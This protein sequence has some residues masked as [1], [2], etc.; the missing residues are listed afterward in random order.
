MKVKLLSHVQLF[1][2]PWT[3]AHQAPQSMEFSRQELYFYKLIITSYST[4]GRDVYS[5][6][7]GG[8][9][10]KVLNLCFPSENWGYVADIVSPLD[11]K[12]IK[13][14]NPKGNQL[15]ILTGRTN[16]E[17]LCYVFTE[18]CLIWSAKRWLTWSARRK[19]G[20]E[21]FNNVQYFGLLM[22]GPTHQKTP[23]F[24][25]RLR[26]GGER[27]DRGWGSCVASLTHWTW[28]WAD[29]RRY[30]RTGKPGVLQSMGSQR[31]GHN[32][33][34]EQQQQIVSFLFRHHSTLFLLTKPRFYSSAGVEHALFTLL[35]L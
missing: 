6:G 5:S 8:V 33:V 35:L 10:W 23:R 25:E 13:S 7:G 17:H 11:C 24:W 34:I 29:S 19:G 31:V 4:T 14:I 15:W 30:W 18:R 22:W 27:G 28:I 1:V 9:L 2:T 20:H 32:L 21:I 16:A 26:V 12:E 3:V